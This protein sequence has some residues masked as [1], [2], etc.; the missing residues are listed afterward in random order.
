MNG[1]A[2]VTSSHRSRVAV[3]YIRQS[4][5]LQV[6]DHGESTAR[7]YALA[8]EAARLGWDAVDVVV[9]DADLGVSGRF[10]A[11][12]G[13]FREVISRVCLG[14][15]GA[16][17]GLEVSRLAR[18]SAEFTRLLELARLT[19]TLVIDADGVYDLSDIN[20]RLL[21]GLKGSMSEAELHLLAGR[22]QGAKRAAAARGELRLPLPVGLVHDLDGQ[23]VLDPDE[24]VRQAVADVFAEFARTGSAY[25]VVTAFTGR[26]F[27]LRA[28]GGVWA[29]QLRWGRLTHARAV[30]VLSNPAYAGAYAYGQ[31]RT[32]RTVR[33]DGSV[34]VAHPRVDR[35]NW[36]VLLLD[37][38]E[39]YLSW[40]QYLDIGQKLAANRTNSGA[41]PP[42]EGVPLCQGIIGCGACGGRVGTRYQGRQARGYY[43]CMSHRDAAR[44][45]S[46]RSVAAH[47]VDD[48]VAALLLAAITPEQIRLALAAAAEVTVRHTRAHRAADLAVQRAR[49]EAEQAERAFTL[50][51]PGNRLVARTLEA[52]WETKLAALAEAE[53]H[54]TLCRDARPPLPDRD[55]LHRLAE[56]LPRLWDASTTSAK[57]R[58]RLLRTVIA[59]VTLLPSDD[60]TECRIG[61]R[62]HT[63]TT[64]EIVTGRRGPDRTPPGAVELARRLGSVLSDEDL[65]AALNR[66]GH[67]TGKGRP[68]DVK[69]VRWIRH[70]YQIRA[71][72]TQ[73]L[74]DGE[75]TVKQAA[76]RLGISADAVYQWLSLGQ[77]P[78]RKDP[79]GRWCI[80]WNPAT[81]GVYQCKVDLS[82]H[83][84]P[85][86]PLIPAGGAV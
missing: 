73:C 29:G 84:A 9:I 59:D 14:E 51:D 44:T 26:T 86:T 56:D 41:R 16:V 31:H 45:Q 1:E 63:G 17:F 5:M 24:Q 83:L 18:S 19:D 66:G 40:A 65:A 21:L 55:S 34:A 12:R 48:A 47:T 72:R 79:T 35:A 30:G 74:R 67:R 15:V 8:E 10:G 78:A 23:I 49:Y 57:D 2:K 61:V 39:G 3:I 28:Y 71:P 58:K 60:A 6:R 27:P 46:C 13:G 43:E 22:L 64:D 11:D 54:L 37:H 42:R 32:A 53:A 25:G 70:A 4:T 36:Q 82:V 50:V 77:V 62:W 75:I 38:H 85:A 7:Q 52:R 81:I 33:P 69:A 76:A 68:F 20:D 80:P